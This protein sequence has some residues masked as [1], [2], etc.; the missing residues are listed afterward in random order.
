MQISRLSSEL[1]LRA[2]IVTMKINSHFHQNYA[3]SS[4]SSQLSLTHVGLYKYAAKGGAV[5]PTQRAVTLS[6]KNFNSLLRVSDRLIGDCE[7]RQQRLLTSRCPRCKRP[8]NTSE[9]EEEDDEDEMEEEDVFSTDRGDDG[10]YLT[11]QLQQQQQ[12]PPTTPTGEPTYSSAKDAESWFDVKQR[13]KKK[14]NPT[15][16]TES[17]R[18]CTDKV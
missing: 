10:A 2:C 3:T 8:H 7:K 14:K 15:K 1:S 16:M 13:K 18:A 17:A 12:P 4:V 5:K 9:E 11:Q 6:L